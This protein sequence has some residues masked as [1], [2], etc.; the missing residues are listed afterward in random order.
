MGNEKENKREWKLSEVVQETGLSRKALQEYDRLGIVS[1]TSKTEGG[2]WLYDDKAVD[3]LRIVATF[4]DVGYKRAEIKELLSGAQ[5]DNVQIISENLGTAIEKLQKQRDRIDSVISLLK[6]EQDVFDR[7]SEKIR[8]QVEY[9]KA[10]NFRSKV[11]TA[12]SFSKAV[13]FMSFIGYDE[14]TR[15]EIRNAMESVILLHFFGAYVDEKP[16]SD[17]VKAKMRE[18]FDAWEQ[19]ILGLSSLPAEQREEYGKMQGKEK[20]ESTRDF[21]FLIAEAQ[22]PENMQNAKTQMD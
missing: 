15:E 4:R 9:L 1:P 2:Y 21:M 20:L 14:N 19:Y 16:D 10:K 13:N 17:I 8:N 6:F 5:G 3:K 22:T 18:L 11:S 7:F 12:D